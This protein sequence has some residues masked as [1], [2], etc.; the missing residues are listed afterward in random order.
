MKITIKYKDL[1]KQ[2]EEYNQMFISHPDVPLSPETL[3]EIE[4]EEVKKKA[5]NK[6]TFLWYLSF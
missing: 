2:I 1:Q 4:G 6:G 3:I 5:P